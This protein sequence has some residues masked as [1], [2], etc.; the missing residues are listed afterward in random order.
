[1]VSAP[2]QTELPTRSYI[3]DSH[4]AEEAVSAGREF[5]NNAFAS[6]EFKPRQ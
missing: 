3:K 2:D 4:P 6:L 5:G 1:V